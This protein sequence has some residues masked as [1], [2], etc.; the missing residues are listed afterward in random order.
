MTDTQHK[1]WLIVGISIALLLVGFLVFLGPGKDA[2]F[3]K[4]VAPDAPVQPLSACNSAWTS[5]TKYTLTTDLTVSTTCFEFNNVQ[6]V[7]LDCEGRKMTVTGSSASAVLI[8]GTSNDVTIQNCVFQGSVNTGVGVFISGPSTNIIVNDNIFANLAQGLFIN[9]ANNNLVNR[10]IFKEN[11][12]A[13]IVSASAGNIFT[14]NNLVSNQRGVTVSGTSADNVFV[15][16]VVTTNSI[17]GITISSAGSGTV[18][19]FLNNYICGNDLVCTPQS[20]SI[21]GKDNYLGAS[22]ACAVGTNF[23]AGSCGATIPDLS[24]GCR[25]GNSCGT[26]STGGSGSCGTCNSI[27]EQCVNGLCEYVSSVLCSPTTRQACTAV[28]C[29]TLGGGLWNSGQCVL[30]GSVADGLACTEPGACISNNCVSGIC[31][32][33]PPA[34]VCGNNIREGSEQCDGTDLAAQTCATQGLP[35]GTLRCLSCNFDRSGCTVQLPAN[36]VQPC[37]L[38][39]DG[40]RCLANNPTLCRRGVNANIVSCDVIN[41]YCSSDSASGTVNCIAKKTDGATC[42]FP[43]ECTSNS[44]VGGVCVAVPPAAVCGNGVREGAETC[45]DGNTVSGDRCSS[46]C[47][48]ESNENCYDGTDNNGDTFVDCRDIQC[49][50]YDICTNRPAGSSC[51]DS[52]MC[53]SGL[54]CNTDNVCAST[55]PATLLGDATCDSRVTLADAILIARVSS[56]IPGFTIPA[57]CSNGAQVSADVTCDSRVTLADA[58][59]TARV[60]SRIPGFTIPLQCS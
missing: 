44:C 37:G 23:Q 16:N 36:V 43:A 17:S 33:A 35:A 27:G 57:T 34:A 49:L 22:A 4:A 18:A 52:R 50:G 56:R 59:L 3:G 9:N 60:S 55:T 26:P 28:N 39:S 45:D 51:F 54:S 12:D 41:A 46:I 58:I 21:E 30:R 53:A 19:T 25:I 10:N 31:A 48:V 38:I 42:Q 5:G 14:R 15:S 29:G 32:A 7:L 13:V 6:N 1:V 40:W 2:L 11:V 24:S 47:L 20:T 8:S